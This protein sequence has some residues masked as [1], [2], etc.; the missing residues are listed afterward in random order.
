MKFRS[1]TEQELK[2]YEKA[3]LRQLIIMLPIALLILWGIVT[4]FIQ[5]IKH[6]NL[7]QTELLLKVPKSFVCNF[8]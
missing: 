7:T 1:L 5:A 2:D 8:E 6:P 4:T 3:Q